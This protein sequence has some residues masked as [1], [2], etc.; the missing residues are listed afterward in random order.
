[1]ERA[2]F[3]WSKETIPLRTTWVSLETTWLSRSGLTHYL[4]IFPCRFN[5]FQSMP[6]CGWSSEKFHNIYE[7]LSTHH[8]SRR[9][10]QN[11]SHCSPRA[12]PAVYY[13]F[14]GPTGRAHCR[15][16]AH[17][18]WARPKA[19][20]IPESTHK[21]KSDMVWEPITPSVPVSVLVEYEG[22][23]WS[24]TYTP[25]IEGELCLVLIQLVEKYEIIKPQIL[26][27]SLVLPSSKSP[28]SL[29]VPRLPPASSLAM[30]PL[31][32]FSP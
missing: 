22:M 29:M 24:P 18:A 26:L 30:L 1:M 6:A 32:P 25:T 19:L 31:A 27:L 11:Q 14:C 17:G 9:R 15:P 3:W 4:H 8:L 28:L 5:R 20:F 2:P 10:G 16:R 13:A 21:V 7:S 12:Q 23:E